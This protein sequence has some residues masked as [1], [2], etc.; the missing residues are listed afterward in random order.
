MPE[1]VVYYANYLVN[2]SPQIPLERKVRTLLRISISMVRTAV[3][4]D[5]LC[6]CGPVV[7][8]GVRLHVIVTLST[9]DS[10]ST[11]NSQL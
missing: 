11:L 2:N 9:N 5:H 1:A 8:E 10:H 6:V 7:V 4:G 3:L